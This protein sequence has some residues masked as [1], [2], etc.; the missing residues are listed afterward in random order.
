MSA[1]LHWNDQPVAFE[2]GETI[3]AA[4]ARA[5]IRELGAGRHF[6]GIGLCQN[7]VVLKDG[8]APVEACL[9]PAEAG[10]RLTALNQREATDVVRG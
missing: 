4:L 8:Q 7:C 3:S 9:T 6:C 1:V 2:P 10:M 5:G